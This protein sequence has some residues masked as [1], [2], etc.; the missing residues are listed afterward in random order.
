MVGGSQVRMLKLD[1]A[2]RKK[3]TLGEKH[4]AKHTG[5]RSESSPKG[6]C[7]APCYVYAPIIKKN[8]ESEKR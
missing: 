3:I 6:D 1:A 4:N 5:S 2:T 7:A 8:T